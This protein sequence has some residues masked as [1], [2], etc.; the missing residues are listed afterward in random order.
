M[1]VWIFIYMHV[2]GICVP[3]DCAVHGTVR[4]HTDTS[5]MHV[6]IDPHDQLDHS[7]FTY[8]LI[9]IFITPC[10]YNQRAV[11]HGIP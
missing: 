9:N 3:M 2:R 11:N 4:R 1:I 6:D 8:I 5:H 10:F 7:F